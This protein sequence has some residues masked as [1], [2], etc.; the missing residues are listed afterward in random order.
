M[1]SRNP[2]N[3]GWVPTVD[4]VSQSISFLQYTDKIRGE[5][6]GSALELVGEGQTLKQISGISAEMQLQPQEMMAALVSRNIAETLVRNLFV[7]IHRTLRTG[8]NTPL[9]FN[10]SGDWQETM[11]SDWAP[12]SR[13]NVNVGLSPGERRRQ[14]QALQFVIE[15]QMA[16]IQGGTANI[17][18]TWNG[19]NSSVVTIPNLSPLIASSG[20][21]TAVGL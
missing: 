14:N 5:Q 1:R 3:V 19:P 2:S 17:T 20:T 16:L 13:L 12:R 11:P 9:M 7:L 21:C 4:V 6:T 10:K 8:W 18:T 15:T